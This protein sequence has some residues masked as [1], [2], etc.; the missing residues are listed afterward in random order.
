VDGLI[1]RLGSPDRIVA[2]VEIGKRRLPAIQ[3]DDQ[4]AGIV[5]IDEGQ[6]PQYQ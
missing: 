3:I 5:P 6:P 2:S 1:G 4:M